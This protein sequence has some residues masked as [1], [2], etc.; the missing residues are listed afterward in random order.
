LNAKQ[1][2]EQNK[3]I[4]DTWAAKQKRRCMKCHSPDQWPGLQIHEMEQKSAAPRSWL[5]PCNFLLLCQRDHEGFHN[6]NTRDSHVEQLRVKIRED[7][8]HFSLGKWLTL[9]PRGEDYITMEDLSE[10]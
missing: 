5:D 6:G 10:N 2:Y 1:Y 7:A 8:E 4:R 9:R 3:A